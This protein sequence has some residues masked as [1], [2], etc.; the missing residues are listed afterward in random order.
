MIVVWGMAISAAAAPP[1]LER[2]AQ[3]QSTANVEEIVKIAREIADEILSVS[4]APHRLTATVV[5]LY[6]KA[7]ALKAA[8][9]TAEDAGRLGRL[10]LALSESYASEAKRYLARSVKETGNLEDRVALGNAELY[11]GN[12]AAA[13]REYLKVSERRPQDPVLLINIAL[14]ERAL[15]DTAS[16]YGRL[17]QVML[18]PT[19]V[20][21]ERA[22]SLAI[23]DIQFASKDVSGAKLEVLKILRKWPTDQEALM[24]LK[25]IYEK[26]G[27]TKLAKEVESRLTAQKGSEGTTRQKGK[28]ARQ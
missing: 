9:L 6:R 24:M 7:E 11:L 8:A 3:A 27:Q 12:A 28:G 15:G 22:A 4:A 21:V 17:R 14:V 23:A 1:A 20:S 26:E 10:Y 5:G 18:R 19:S 13:R 2:I 25:K 16:A